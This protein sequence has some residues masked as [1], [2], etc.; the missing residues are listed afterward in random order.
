V[1]PIDH[2]LKKEEGKLRRSF[3][4]GRD[5]CQKQKKKI[6]K[7][8]REITPAVAIAGNRENEPGVDIKWKSNLS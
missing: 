5:V 2:D 6:E 1:S 4:D 7:K 8:G 3:K